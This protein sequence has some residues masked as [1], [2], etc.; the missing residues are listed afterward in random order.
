M[1]E[2]SVYSD[3]KCVFNSCKKNSTS[4]NYKSLIS[5]PLA[6]GI[7]EIMQ[8]LLGEPVIA[9]NINTAWIVGDIVD[10]AAETTEAF[11]N[12]IQAIADFCKTVNKL[13]NDTIWC[14]NNPL[15][16]FYIILEWITPF[17]IS[18]ATIFPVLGIIIYL[19]GSKKFFKWTTRQIIINPLLIY[20]AFLILKLIVGSLI[21]Y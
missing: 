1:L 12:N 4:N 7:N 15:S 3:Y 18:I 10:G 5:F 9:S 8:Q 11:K 2:I 17:M 6:L 16:C 13:I 14:F 21:N 20:V 19:A